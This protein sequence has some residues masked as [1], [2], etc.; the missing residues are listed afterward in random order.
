MRAYRLGVT[1]H[2]GVDPDEVKHGGVPILRSRQPH[3][4]IRSNSEPVQ[5]G[6]AQIL[7]GNQMSY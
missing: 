3:R 6:T 2:D 7:S 1:K 5:Q 4:S